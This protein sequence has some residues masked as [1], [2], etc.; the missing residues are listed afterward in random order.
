MSEILGTLFKYLAMALGVAAV[1]LILY[2]VMG[3]NKTSQAVSDL[4]QLSASIQSVYA[5]QSSFN[6]LDT[7]VSGAPKTFFPSSMGDT[8]SA[9]VD[10][11]GNGV[12]VTGNNSQFSVALSNSGGGVPDK[13]C[14]TLATS[15]SYLNV[16][17]NGKTEIAPVSASNIV[18]DCNNS[19]HNTMSFTFGH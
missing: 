8:Y 4:S 13:A 15:L 2:S 1:M 6:G 10:P 3:S 16:Q 7:A 12:T 5:G 17:I 19:D 9:M 14:V 11:W 18:A